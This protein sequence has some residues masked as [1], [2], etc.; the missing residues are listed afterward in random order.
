MVFT[1]ITSALAV[2]QNTLGHC[3]GLGASAKAFKEAPYLRVELIVPHKSVYFISM[4]TKK[5][6]NQRQ[7]GMFCILFLDINSIST[8]SQVLDIVLRV[9]WMKLAFEMDRCPLCRVAIC[10]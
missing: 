10:C 4:V 2:L 5:K 6:I 7:R 3:Q 9:S 8:N 1:L